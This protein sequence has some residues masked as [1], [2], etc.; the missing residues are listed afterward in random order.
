MHTIKTC[1]DKEPVFDSAETLKA[2]LEIMSAMISTMK[3]NSQAML[4]AARTGFMN[5]TDLA[6]YLTVKG[7]PFR[8]AYKISGQLVA[9]CIREGKILEDLSLEDYRQYSA[10]FSEDIYETIDIANCV[11]RRC[12]RGG[13][14]PESVDMQ[15]EYIKSFLK[16]T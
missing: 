8:D 4:S 15:I 7:V 13:T 14:S 3:V 9:E 5:A 2:C 1:R 10:L 6:D 16:E 11:K 12:S